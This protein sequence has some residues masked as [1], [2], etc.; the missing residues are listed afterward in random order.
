[1]RANWYVSMT[2]LSHDEQAWKRG[3]VYVCDELGTTMSAAHAKKIMK[4]APMY[5]S[6]PGKLAS[7][8]YCVADTAIRGFIHVVMRTMPKEMRLRF[9][10]HFGGTYRRCSLTKYS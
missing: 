5:Y 8:H 6:F 9:R 3:L 4:W 7:C 2:I 10:F 1:M